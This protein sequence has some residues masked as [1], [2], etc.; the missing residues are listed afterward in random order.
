[1]ARNVIYQNFLDG[2]SITGNQTLVEGNVVG[3]NPSVPGSFGNLGNGIDIIGDSNTVGG[4][5][6]AARNVINSNGKA[7]ASVAGDH[8]VVEGNYIGTDAAGMAPLPNFGA[9]I[10][11]S[12]GSTDGTIIG[13]VVSGNQGS[14]IRVAG[15][16]TGNTVQ[17]NLIGTDASGSGRLPNG[18]DGVDLTGTDTESN[19]IGGAAAGA[20][21]VIAAN[22]GFGI[23]ITAGSSSNTIQGN[24]IGTDKTSTH[25]AGQRSR[26]HRD[27]EQQQQHRRRNQQHHERHVPRC[28]QH[29]QQ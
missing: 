22:L 12:L 14:G 24:F 19:T 8:N 9:G 3:A 1:M 10:D 13:N 28:W 21:N 5:S 7:G 20:G 4:T 16:S 25:R 17:G 23:G 6:V 18:G 15:S 11:L 29:H 26:R 2:V 27:R